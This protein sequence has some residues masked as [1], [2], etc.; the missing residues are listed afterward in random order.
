MTIDITKLVYHTAGHDAQGKPVLLPKPKPP[1]FAA[2]PPVSR[3]AYAHAAEKEFDSVRL[4]A[5]NAAWPEKPSNWDK[6]S[7][8]DHRQWYHQVERERSGG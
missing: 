3:R 5:K 6:G 4:A 2:A 1:E 7:A 8:A